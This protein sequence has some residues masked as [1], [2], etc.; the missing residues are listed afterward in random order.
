MSR[1]FFSDLTDE[2][3]DRVSAM[4]ASEIRASAHIVNGGEATF[5]CP[6]CKGT[7]KFRGRN[8]MI[9]GDCF[10]CKG[11][12]NVSKGVAAA[13]K[14]KATREA[15]VLAYRE[16]HAGE[17]QY[18]RG[19]AEKSTFYAGLLEK[20]DAYG[21]WTEGQIAL[22]R[23]DMVEHEEFLAKRREAQVAERESKSGEVNI[24]AIQK[25]FDTAVNNAIKKPIFRTD[26]LTL[27]K[28]PMTGR[29]PGALYVTRTDSDE[30][31]GK[32]VGE[33]FE[34]TRAAN[35]DDLEQLR[36]LAIDPTAEAIKYARRTGNC[37][38]CGRHLVDPVSILAV[39]GPICAKKWGLDHLRDEAREEYAE[40]KK[41]EGR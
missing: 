10:K 17:I 18:A 30:Y 23:R 40:M 7:G 20:L 35:T 33:K 2:Q 39:I 4:D 41:E 28:A 37:S 31:V 3:F 1:D 19:R 11:K 9:L 34:A 5:P 27:S 8:G 16:Q 36:A 25:L 22:I 32:I 12:G 13:A 21:T 6:N 15:N 29:N 24:S 14:G 38:C 26:L